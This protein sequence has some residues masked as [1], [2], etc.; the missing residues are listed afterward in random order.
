MPYLDEL[1]AFNNVME[2]GSLTQSAA[3]LSLAKSTLSRRIS[4]LESRLGQPLLKRQANQLLPTEAGHRY[5]TISRQML[6]LAD[7]GQR[8]LDS[9]REDVSGDI[10]LEAHRSLIRS[11]LGS[12][13][14]EFLAQYPAVSV[15]LH[16]RSIPSRDPKFRGVSIWL[17]ETDEGRLRQEV[18]GHLIQGIYAHPDYLKRHGRPDH[19]EALKRHAWI[20]MIGENRN[21]LVLRHPNGEAVNFSPPGSRFR[22]DQATLYMDAIASG[23]GLGVLPCWIA[24]S[25]ERAHPGELVRCLEDWQLQPLKVTLLYGFGHQPRRVSALLEHL[26]QSCPDAW[27]E[28]SGITANHQAPSQREFDCYYG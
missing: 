24:E 9:L 28:A 15:T 2:T 21:G 8:V 4:S 22:V 1:I 5:Y 25:R 27:Q 26:R 7:E 13:I 17:G 14:R 18:I 3:E 20:D 19:P 10:L 23:G 16:T 6:E 11:W 12:S